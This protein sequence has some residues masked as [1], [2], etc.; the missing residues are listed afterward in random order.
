VIDTVLNMD[1]KNYLNW[2]L[3]KKVIY[4]NHDKTNI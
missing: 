1:I 2:Q 3:T 4:L